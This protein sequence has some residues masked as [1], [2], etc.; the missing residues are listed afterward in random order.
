M[1]IVS[2]LI[3]AY[4]AEE[5]ILRT[6]DSAQTQTIDDIE[7]LV[8]DDGSTDRT[9]DFVRSRA[10]ADSRIR[11]H[12][13]SK[14]SGPAA[15]RN[16]GIAMAKGEWIALLDADDT[17][18]RERLERLLE[19]AS[20]QDV[21][22][23][24]NLV[25]YDRHADR[26]VK[27]GVD[28]ALLGSG[29]RLDC[30]GFVARCKGNQ[31]DAV[32]FGLLQQLIR[33]SHI[34]AHGISY[35]EQSRYAEDF[36]FTLDILL[37]GG[38]FLI[39]PEA[40]YQYTERFGSI[41]K[42]HSG[43]S[44]TIVQYDR[45]EA[46]TREL[47]GDRRY[48]R[49]ATQLIERAD[50]IRR[51]AKAADFGRRS[52]LGK[53]ATFL[54]AL[55]DRDMRTHF[56]LRARM[57]LGAL[58]PSQW[59]KN[60]LLKD[61]SN[62]CLGQSIR[63]ALQG[64]YF[65]FI[66]RSLG[67]AQYGAFVA[68]TAMTSIASPYVGL[69]CG[70]LFL[71][72]V[73]AGKREA[74]LCWG[75]GLVATFVTG[76]PVSVVLCA[77]SVVWAPKV[78]LALIA[79]ICLSDLIFV[80][81]IDL[82]S[83]GFA[84]S[85]KMSKTA[86]QNTTMSFLRVIGIVVL[87]ACYR[88]VSIAQWAWVYLV[89]SII[90]G[91]FAIQQGSALWGVPRVSFAALWRDAREG[92][93]FSISISAQTVYND[94]DKTM[95]ARLSTLTAAGVYAAAYRIVDTSLTP[96]RSLVSAAYPRFFR[97]GT[98]GVDATYGYAKRLIRKAVVFGAADFVALLLIA[99]VLPYILG[100]KY[101]SVAPAVRLLALIPVMRCVHWF[102]A[103]ALSGANEQIL[104][105]IVQVGVALLNF[106]LN[107]VILPRWSWVGAAWTSLASDAVLVIAVYAAVQWK[108]SAAKAS[109]EPLVE[110]I[111]SGSEAVPI[112]RRDAA[113]AMSQ[114]SIRPVF[115]PGDAGSRTSASI[116]SGF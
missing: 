14:N 90:G 39:V 5:T 92:T 113:A 25:L 106:G 99:P 23:A 76:L 1:P 100:P 62:L 56:K 42:K 15:A 30:E 26:V 47:A 13:L 32:D 20:A 17:I 73:R 46:Q 59:M 114:T 65:L 18:S 24:D 89:T 105:T 85:G 108:R 57:R 107:L 40:Y 9:A 84:A 70:S 71:K 51:M 87:V 111:G 67:P 22:V 63:L 104:R 21:L 53:L 44:R 61:S 103:D 88:H 54:F 11:L 77:L 102:L 52:H 58:H 19:A 33:V 2:I 98:E 94:I 75:N 10:I 83:F 68:I 41:S 16:A 36:R 29:L 27:L 50:A 66:A 43:V 79:A 112:R 3:P 28:P 95:L 4:N 34:R 115:D 38:N 12:S 109:N 101:A 97:I 91:A 7:I 45:L 48:A 110:R 49:V 80:R 78:P 82:A 86:V 93:F 55:A 69:G 64:I 81:V 37:A 72:N 35:D 6:L 96:V 60:P 74:P 31:P 8:I 116:R